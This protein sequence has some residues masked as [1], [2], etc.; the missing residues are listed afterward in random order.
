M[1]QDACVLIVTGGSLDGDFLR[2]VLKDES[3]CRKSPFI[4]GVDKGL[5]VLEQLNIKPNLAL[6]DFDSADETVREQYISNPEHFE[7]KCMV[8]QS[9]KDF[10]DTHIAVLEAIKLRPEKVIILGATGTRVDHMMA[11]L[12]ILKLLL[13]AGICGQI[14][15]ANNRIT[16]VN[17]KITLYKKNLYGPYVSLIP[18][19]DF[20]SGVTL[21]G[22]KYN[23]E[24]ITIV[25][26]ESIGISNELREEEGFVTLKEGYL[27]VMETKD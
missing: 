1:R 20:V 8:F 25:K 10:S 7:G 5:N 23:V 4:I 15:D 17:D 24:N 22:F 14:L 18:Y 27:Y 2:Q 26:E 13:D 21:K 11:N 9:E 12:G 3:L 19:T 6:G 16:L